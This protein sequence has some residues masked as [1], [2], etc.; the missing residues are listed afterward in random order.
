MLAFLPR[1]VLSS[2]PLKSVCADGSFALPLDSMWTVSKNGVSPKNSLKGYLDMTFIRKVVACFALVL[3]VTPSAF[4]VQVKYFWKGNDGIIDD[5]TQWYVNKWKGAEATV[6]PGAEDQINFSNPTS[7]SFSLGLTNNLA[8]AQ[9]NFSGSVQATLDVGDCLFN[10]GKFVVASGNN[11][12]NTTR[13][14]FVSGRV[15]SGTSAMVGNTA[16]R[17][18]GYLRMSD[19]ASI[20]VGGG[21]L[22]VQYASFVDLENAS[23]VG[24]NL[25]SQTM[26]FSG[27][28]EL[29]I[30]GTNSLLQTTGILGFKSGS[31][32]VFCPPRDA[33][34]L[35]R[36]PIQAYKL[37]STDKKDNVTTTNCTL[38]V[39]AA[40]ARKCAGHGGGRY[41]LVKGGVT[42]ATPNNGNFTVFP[43]V[44]APDFVTVEQDSKNAQIWVTVKPI[45]FVVIIR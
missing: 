11:G 33:A 17:G 18:P 26:Y 29:R 8:V 34:P 42:T 9:V 40:A 21:N 38:R 10:A 3:L 24:T 35:V 43:S 1:L 39:D 20:D 6:V 15:L 19:G 28:S 14:D 27:G 41:L 32:L 16:D 13:V 22:T 45:G 37:N 4:A 44:E 31:T 23:V 25:T 2:S 30:E 12:V 36:T 5:V 7:A